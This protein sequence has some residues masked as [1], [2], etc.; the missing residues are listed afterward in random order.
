MPLITKLGDE[1]GILSVRAAVCSRIELDKYTHVLTNGLFEHSARHGM[2]G[3]PVIATALK[4]VLT[5]E[6]EAC[7][8]NGVVSR[9]QV[10]SIKHYEEYS[11]WLRLLRAVQRGI[12]PK[13]FMRGLPRAWDRLFGVRS[14]PGPEFYSKMRERLAG[15]VSDES[16][17]FM[18]FDIADLFSVQREYCIRERILPIPGVHEVTC[19]CS[20][21]ESSP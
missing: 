11:L 16:L 7:V 8:L 9:I 17:F 10:L 18:C 19:F 13:N 6:A 1:P 21:T 15:S 12:V 4:E 2:V 20:L 3:H 14:I 5:A